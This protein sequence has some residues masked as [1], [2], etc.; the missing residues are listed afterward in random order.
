MA[1][2][3]QRVGNASRGKSRLVGDW[4]RGIVFMSTA[5]SMFTRLDYI[6]QNDPELAA[7]IICEHLRKLQERYANVG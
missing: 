1:L 5:L 3:D 6:V 7:V 2:R 4:V